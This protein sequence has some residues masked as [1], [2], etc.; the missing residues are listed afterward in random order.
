M[1]GGWVAVLG[2]LASCSVGPK[3]EPPEM[4]LAGHYDAGEAL[5]TT[6]ESVSHWWH[7]FEDPLL[8]Q[9]IEEAAVANYDVR[10]AL[11]RIEQTRAQY[12][13]ERS[14]LW[15]EIDLNAIATRTGISQNLLPPPP[16][17]AAA[18]AESSVIPRFLN[19]FQVGFDAIWELDFFGKFRHAKKAAHY[20][21]EATREDY[22]N[23]LTAVTNEVAVAYV[24]IRA[25]QHK[26]A[27]AR[28][29]V[30]ADE[31]KLAILRQLAEVGLEN[32]LQVAEWVA[33][34]EL[35]RAD[36]PPLETSLKQTMYA[37][38]YLVGQ[39]PEGIAARFAE[40]TP[41]PAGSG[42]VPA[43]LPADL[44]RRRPDIRSAERQLAAASEQ[45]G[46]AIA[47]YFPHVVLTGLGLS[48]GNQVGSSVGLESSKLSE[49][50]HSASRMFS[51][52]VGINWDLIDFGRVRGKVDVQ[53]SL[54]RQALLAY[55]QTVIGALKDVE[56]AL[57]AYFEEERRREDLFRQVTA[58]RSIYEITQNLFAVGL[59]EESQVIDAER[60]FLNAERGLIESDQSMTSDLVAVYKAMGGE[61]WEPLETAMENI[62]K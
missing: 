42:R 34:L 28:Q 58:Y 5:P 4:A 49:L 55:E 14:H 19:V 31:R 48:A 43:G 36:L 44:L 30:L 46:V 13:I 33:T 40:R 61:W 26:I 57:V 51:V 38:A 29:K 17:A 41:I 7:Q 11:E 37:L 35:D 47:D 39:P 1:R 45:I 56:S 50:L 54:H 16:D 23:A 10:T 59:A 32:T 27:L 21:W 18:T 3:Y 53:K 60:A 24:G 52:G 25:L 62:P 15:P 20:L 12:R 8:N 2:F 6:T 9:L 22:Q